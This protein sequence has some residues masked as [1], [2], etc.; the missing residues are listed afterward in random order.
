MVHFLLSC[1]IP[2]SY[3]VLSTPVSEN[4]GA[5][6]Q[7]KRKWCPLKL[8]AALPA[9]AA[10]LGIRPAAGATMLLPISNSVSYSIR[11]FLYELPDFAHSVQDF[12]FSCTNCLALHIRIRILQPFFSKWSRKH[13]IFG[14]FK[15]F[16]LFGRKYACF[17]AKLPSMAEELLDFRPSCSS[18]AYM[19]AGIC[20]IRKE[21]PFSYSYDNYTMHEKKTQC[22]CSK[23]IF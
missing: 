14:R 11:L 1:S 16:Y 22:L 15:I 19:A 10:G 8:H 9:V 20:R 12:A 13:L 18:S 23:I 6:Q 3:V 4:Y 21:L 7:R 5:W 2:C 17:L